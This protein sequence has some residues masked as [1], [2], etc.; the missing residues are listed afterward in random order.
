[1]AA[2]SED[3]AS[4]SRYDTNH[5]NLRSTFILIKNESGT[6]FLHESKIRYIPNLLLKQ[7]DLNLPE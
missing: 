4:F 6:L 5:R 1:M 3:N 2:I 7:V